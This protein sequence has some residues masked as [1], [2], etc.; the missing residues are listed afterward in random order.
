MRTKYCRVILA[1]ALFT[2]SALVMTGAQTKYGVTV[3]AVD[4]ARL[5][6]VATYLWTGGAVSRQVDVQITAAIDRELAARGLTKVAS[7][8]SDIVVSYT[9]LG[10]TEVDA[11]T[12]PSKDGTERETSIGTLVVDLRDAITRQS[13]FRA[14]METPIERDPATIGAAIDA[15]VAAVF[16]KY[17]GPPKR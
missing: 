14:R 3:Q 5:A 8:P 6:K 12:A 10:R 15:A 16:A 17:P 7:G 2:V 9:A 4:Q 11:K 13:L 1:T